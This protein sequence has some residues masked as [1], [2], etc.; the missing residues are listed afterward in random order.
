MK[1]LQAT[2]M[3][4]IVLTKVMY[5]AIRSY[6]E[7]AFDNMSEQSEKKNFIIKKSLLPVPS[8]VMFQVMVKQA[9]KHGGFRPQ[10]G[11]PGNT[12][13]PHRVRWPWIS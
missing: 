10:R 2:N 8:Q 3:K 6:D 11:Y 12:L 13:T 9:K 1:L 4:T 5:T 7:E